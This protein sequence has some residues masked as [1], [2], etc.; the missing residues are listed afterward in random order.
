MTA[1]QSRIR[2]TYEDYRTLPED[3]S[4]RYELFHGELYMVPG[5]TTRHQ[6]ILGN[7]YLALRTHAES[8]KLGEVLLAPV[9]VILGHG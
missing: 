7:L 6:R 3:M 4:Q 5:P 2:Y 9:D 8:R 1:S